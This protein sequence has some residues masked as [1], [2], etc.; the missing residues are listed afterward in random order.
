M[1]P[2]EIS[3]GSKGSAHNRTTAAAQSSTAKRAP[4]SGVTPITQPSRVSANGATSSRSRLATAPQAS[5]SRQAMRRMAV[6]S[7]CSRR[8]TSCG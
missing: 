7:A 2:V 6:W 1:R 8:R 3:S 5:D 4:P